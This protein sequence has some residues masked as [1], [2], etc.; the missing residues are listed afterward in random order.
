MESLEQYDE[1]L[2]AYLSQKRYI[3]SKN[4][5]DASVMLAKK[6]G[7]TDVE[8][9]RF[10][11]LV[12]DICKEEPEDV[13]YTLMM[14]SSMDVCMEERKAFK[15]WHGIAGAE[16]LRT[17]FGVTDEDVLHAVRFHTVGRAGM[18]NLEKIVYLADM[19]SAERDYP[20]VDVMREKAAE[21][22][23]AGM[24]YALKYS[25]IKLV[26]REALIPHHIA[27]T[28]PGFSL[29]VFTNSS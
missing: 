17:K 4:V 18:S 19:I 20:D 22:L 23:N 6:F 14:Q 2:K 26:R 29:M 12:H 28:K 7:G 27:F 13:Q 9:A 24:A 8:T 25:L 1:Y 15:V 3:H 16:L 5:S 21:S 10:A 11:G